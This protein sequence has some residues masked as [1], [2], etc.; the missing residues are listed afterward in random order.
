MGIWTQWDNWSHT[1]P[2]R[3]KAQPSDRRLVCRSSLC[4]NKESLLGGGCLACLLPLPPP[5]HQARDSSVNNAQ[6]WVTM[7]AQRPS[8]NSEPMFSMLATQ[9]TLVPACSGGLSRCGKLGRCQEQRG[10]LFFIWPDSYRGCSQLKPSQRLQCG[11]VYWGLVVKS[12]GF[13]GCRWHVPVK[14]LTTVAWNHWGFTTLKEL[15][16]MSCSRMEE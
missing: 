4:T 16:W 2:S 1:Y 11:R 14:S 10:C 15:R 3:L 8:P 13:L 7:P 5:C 6:L 9:L 12:T